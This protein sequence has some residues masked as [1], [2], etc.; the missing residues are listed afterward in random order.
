ML[1]RIR[2]MMIKMIITMKMMRMRMTM[3]MMVTM[4]MMDG[5]A[6][7]DEDDDD[8]NEFVDN[9]YDLSDDNTNDIYELMN[10]LQHLS[11]Y[12]IGWS[13]INFCSRIE[14]PFFSSMCIGHTKVPTKFQD[15]GL[16][17]FS[18]PPLFVNG[19]RPPRKSFKMT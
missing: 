11:N 15:S 7:Y 1:M 6:D 18:R 14:P 9:D 10:L 16:D 5:G 12:L 8:N 17:T 2:M 13:K 3:V 19:S 4:T